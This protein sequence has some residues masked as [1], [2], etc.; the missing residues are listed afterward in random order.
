VRRLAITALMAT[1]FLAPRPAQAQRGFDRGGP[2][3]ERN[4]ARL[5][6]RL[7]DEMWAYRQELDVFRNTPVFVRL[8]DLRYALR[9][10]AIRVVELEDRGPRARRAQYEASQRMK[11]TADELKRLTGRLEERTDDGAPREV[12][13][14]AD[15]M[16]EHA[17]RIEDMIDRLARL[18]RED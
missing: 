4:I 7:R 14:R 18:T 10:Q 13:R 5:M 8:V 11:K 12:R 9:E 16:K 15:R 6:D 17:D 2:G 3:D 1:A